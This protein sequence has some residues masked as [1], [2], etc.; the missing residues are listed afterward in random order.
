[1]DRR[2]RTLVASAAIQSI[3]LCADESLAVCGLINGRLALF[4]VPSGEAVGEIAAHLDTVSAVAFSPDGTLVASASL[5]RTVGLWEVDGSSLT[6]LFHIPSPSGHPVLSVK[7]DAGG[8]V[9]GILVQ[10][11]RAVRLWNLPELRGRLKT[12]G[13]DWE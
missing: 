10:N 2:S 6:E 13:L 12:L 11:E 5:D 1:M 3:A 8:T 9:L 7:F 4:R